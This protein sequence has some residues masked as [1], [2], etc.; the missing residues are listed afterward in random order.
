MKSLPLA[1]VFQ[2]FVYIRTRFRFPMIGR[3]VTAQSTW[4][5]MGIGGEIQFLQT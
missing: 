5:H 3:N 2:C 4:R 1:H